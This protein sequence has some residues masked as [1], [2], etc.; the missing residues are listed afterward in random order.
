MLVLVVLWTGG[1]WG[2]VFDCLMSL[3]T[4]FR[5]MRLVVI[6]VH[7]VRGRIPHVTSF[8]RIESPA[9]GGKLIF[10][11]VVG[12]IAAW[13]C[14]LGCF[15]E[16]AVES[17]VVSCGCHVCHVCHVVNGNRIGIAYRTPK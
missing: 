14:D 9:F 12:I 15:W 16:T 1:G 7:R 3:A 4:P 8:L 6:V 10:Q 11:R 17:V 5:A 13:R 2:W